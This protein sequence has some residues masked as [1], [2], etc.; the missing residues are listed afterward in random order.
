MG[1]NAVRLEGLRKVFTAHGAPV[2][3]VDG[4]SLGVPDGTLLTLLGPSGCG[5][6]TVLRMVAGLEEPTAGEIYVGGERITAVPPN[7]RRTAMVFQSY[8]LFP[9]MTVVDNI[10]YGLRVAGR[11][12]EEI[13]RRVAAMID[14]VGLGGTE[15]RPPGQLSGGQQQRVAVARALVIE[16]RVFLLDEPLSNLDAKLRVQMRHEIRKLQQRLGITTIYVT[17]DQ[18]EAMALS[19]LIAVMHGGR[20][21]QVGTPAEIYARPRSRF[22]ADFVGKANFVPARVAAVGGGTVEADALGQRWVIRADGVE[23][24]ATASVLIRPE[25]IVVRPADQGRFPGEVLTSTYLGGEVIY[26]V[27]VCG[28]TLQA[29]LVVPGD[30][31]RYRPGDRVA[32]DLVGE[33]LHLIR[34]ERG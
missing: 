4:V 2:T 3:A 21:D 33:S 31:P 13:R 23:A 9:H 34:P 19:D 1:G 32:I 11:P 8:G 5:K 15:E 28:V 27:A 30:A 17:H 16:P 22:V 25:A 26:E 24:G 20:V 10:A 14:L 12:R 18:E 7:R 6:T 29:R